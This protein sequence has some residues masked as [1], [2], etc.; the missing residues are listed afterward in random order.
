MS[1][2]NVTRLA[3]QVNTE[4]VRYSCRMD[5]SPL[6]FDPPGNGSPVLHI[7]NQ[8]VSQLKE[9]QEVEMKWGLGRRVSLY[10]SM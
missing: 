5:K 7:D 10:I 6:I 3:G 2:E 1:L 8:K 4:P 9:N